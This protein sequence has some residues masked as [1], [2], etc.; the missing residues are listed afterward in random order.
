MAL[1]ECK[2]C[3]ASV[4]KNAKQCPHCGAKRQRTFQTVVGAIGGLGCALLLAP[5][6]IV[7]L[8]VCMEGC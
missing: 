8:L 3:G 4:A 5:G 1:T 6:L 7:L 2:E